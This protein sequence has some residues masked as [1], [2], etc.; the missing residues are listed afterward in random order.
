MD[1]VPARVLGR[2]VLARV[3]TSAT[4][5]ESLNGNLDACV[6]ALES[7]GVGYM[8]VAARAGQ[9]RIVGVPRSSRYE[10]FTAL[11]RELAQRPVYVAGLRHRRLVRVSLAGDVLRRS[12]LATLDAVRVFEVLAAAYGHVLAGPEFSCEIQFWHEVAPEE[13]SAGRPTAEGDT[14]DDREGMQESELAL[15]ERPAGVSDDTAWT[16]VAPT[17]NPY[18]VEIPPACQVPA[19]R[20]VA[21][22]PYRTLEPFTRSNPFDIDFPVD[23]VYTWVD[24]SDPLWRARQLTALA[25]VSP[26]GL[27]ELATNASRFVSRDELRYS[28]RSLDMYT[29]W[30]RTVWLVTDDQTP[31]WLNT[32][33]PR[34]RMVSH[35]QIFDDEECL[36][37]FNSHAIE[38]RLHHVEGLSGRYLYLNDDVFFG[39]CV[40]PERFFFANGVAKFFLS[41]AHVALG[42]ASVDEPP[43]MSAGKN[44]RAL[45]ERTFGKT[46]AQKLK[47]VPHSQI[48][49]VLFEME[50]VFAE[51]FR[52]T[53]RTR[54]RHPDNISITSALHH[55][56]AFL[57]GRSVPGE[58]RYFYA[59]IAAPET[60]GR[61]R[62][63]LRE[64]SFDVFCLNDH[65]DSGSDPVTQARMIREFLEAYYPLPSSFER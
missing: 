25:R 2:V 61:L 3:V 63:M 49:D 9:R 16:L 10:T 24:G 59:D 5:E 42:E 47:H 4:A 35:R 17:S 65:D 26:G 23:V 48:R 41:K 44:N 54:F 20:T 46:M 38:S 62:T 14:E 40:P 27:N 8:L 6:R 55:Y 28:L 22:R 7:A 30:V 64:R 39:R 15:P 57:T 31:E 45:L 58:L 51:D 53:S 18:A 21:G 1:V 32:D 33:H 56:Y 29:G 13:T 36:P 50:E 12:G 11:S 37:T 43:V 34:L 52:K 60:P 19:V